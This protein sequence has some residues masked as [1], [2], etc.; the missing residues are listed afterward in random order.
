MPWAQLARSSH[1]ASVAEQQAYVLRRDQMCRAGLS[2]DAL[3]AQLSAG[4]WRTCG[5]AVVV[6]HNGP[7][8]PAQRRWVAVLAAGPDGALCGLTAAALDGLTG[9]SDDTVHVLV[10]RGARPAATPE[11]R[12]QVHESR[13]Y[14]PPDDRHPLRLPPRTRTERSLVDA[15]V[16]LRSPRRACGL[17]VA[18][19]Q[20]RLATAA[21]LAAALTAAGRVRHRRVLTAVLADVDGGAEAL[22]E[23]DFAAFCRRHGFPEPIRQAVRL[24]RAGRRRFLDA[25]FRRRD[26]RAVYVEVDGAV[27]L[28]VGTYWDDMARGNEIVI[29]GDALLRFASVA[30]YLDEPVVADQLRRALWL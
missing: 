16:W 18:G 6:L 3:Q 24:D 11:V 27:H 26:G 8:T 20:Q 29:A 19:V 22:S 23:L 25:E 2:W 12:V 14:R 13:R 1:L 10:R 17:M 9:W 21:G 28:V 7:L 5:P 4:R 15:A 30:L